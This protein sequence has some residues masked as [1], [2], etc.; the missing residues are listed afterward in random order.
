MKKTKILSI[1]SLMAA[2][3]VVILSVGIWMESLDLSLAILAGLI[4]M[5]VSCEFGD[6]VAF[7]VFAV[8]SILSLILQIRLPAIYF[9][10]LF[11]WYPIVQKKIHLLPPWAAKVVKF[12][13]F[14]LLLALYLYLSSKF[15]GTEEATWIY[16]A[17]WILANVCFYVYD[18]LLDRFL[19]W[20]ILKIRQRLRLK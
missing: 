1:A 19:I 4:V 7:S 9:A 11:G 2:M 14:N 10:S 15:T 6:P 16:G 3:C 12:L 8:V 17:F 5:I 20:Y 13:G 18:I